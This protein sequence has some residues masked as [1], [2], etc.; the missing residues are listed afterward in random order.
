MALS[1]SSFTPPTGNVA[2]AVSGIK[3]NAP[4]TTTATFTAGSGET[5][6]PGEYRQY[7][8]GTFKVNGTALDHVLCNSVKLLPTVFQQDG[9]PPSGCTAYGYRACPDH[10]YNKFTPDRAK[11]CQFSMYDAP[12]FNNI[13][14]PGTYNLDLSFEGKLVN[15]AS[16]GAVLV[17]G[18][19]TTSGSTVVTKALSLAAASQLTLAAT[20]KIIGAHVARNAE[21]GANELHIVISRPPDQPPLNGAAFKIAAIDAAG[22]SVVTHTKPPAVYEV[23]GPRRSTVSIVYELGSEA[24]P[25]K[26][27]L[28]VNSGQVTLKVENRS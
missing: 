25:A 17:S 18:S 2:P 1:Y 27:A 23:G 5:C 6:A 9:C 3:F 8:K 22:K 12:G 15:T 20:D 21:S 26:V 24:V 28:S 14:A 13:T 4:F 16:G 19:W 11:G 10:P 7:V